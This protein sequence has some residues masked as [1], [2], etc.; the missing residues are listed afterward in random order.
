MRV[1]VD[2][3]SP[4]AGVWMAK[5]LDEF[6]LPLVVAKSTKS[7][8]DAE[9]RLEQVMY[10]LTSYHARATQLLVE[11]KG[12]MEDAR[13]LGVHLRGRTLEGIG[14]LL[15]ANRTKYPEADL[16]LAGQCCSA[17]EGLSH[18]D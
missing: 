16:S 9:Q 13:E 17:K 15:A 18:G 12:E 2:E 1:A 4:G 11:A 14:Q 8:D 6:G 5:L 7:R 10:W 3:L